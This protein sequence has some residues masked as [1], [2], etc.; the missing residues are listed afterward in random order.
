M[1]FSFCSL[2]AYLIFATGILL[3]DPKILDACSPDMAELPT[4]TFRWT[5]TQENPEA[6]LMYNILFVV[7]SLSLSL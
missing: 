7:V 3:L 1:L 6:L 4:C 2:F 5:T